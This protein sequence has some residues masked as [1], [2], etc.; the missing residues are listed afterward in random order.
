MKE[1][2]KRKQRLRRKYILIRNSVQDKIKK[3]ELIMNKIIEENS[4]KNA[5]IVA[6]YKNFKSEVDTTK[7]I[8]Y[9]I[10]IGKTVVLPKVVDNELKFYQINSSEN[11]LIKSKFGVEEPIGNE[12]DYVAK[13]KIDIV[14]VPGLCFDKEKNRLGFGKGYYDKYLINTELT[15]I[16]ICFDEQILEETTIPITNGD[17]KIQKIVT[18]IRVY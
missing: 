15:T 8:K 17:V 7:L 13:E 6:L 10:D 2:I 14:I 18:D 5:R 12:K 11:V 16:A 4:Y 9:S 3:S 1:I